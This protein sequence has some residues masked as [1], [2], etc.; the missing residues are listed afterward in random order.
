MPVTSTSASV[1]WSTKSGAG[2][3]IGAVTLMSTAPRSSTGSPMTFR[4][5]PSVSLP[6][7]IEI[8]PPVSSTS[9]PRVRPSVASMAIVRTVN[10]PSCC[11]TSSTSLRPPTSVVSAF[12]IGGSDFSSWNCTSTTAP[13]TWVT[14]PTATFS[15]TL[16][17]FISSLPRRSLSVRQTASAPEMISISSLVICACRCRL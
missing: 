16:A 8:G 13:S 9:L 17:S 10:S 14:R 6:T 5:R 4:M 1:D 11:A 12:R 3:W 2:A 15:F 7:G